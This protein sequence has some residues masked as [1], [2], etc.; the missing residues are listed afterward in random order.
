MESQARMFPVNPIQF[1]TQ[2]IL[3]KHSWCQFYSQGN[4]LLKGISQVLLSFLSMPH[5]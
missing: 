4:Q 2:N 3:L 5:I 1:R